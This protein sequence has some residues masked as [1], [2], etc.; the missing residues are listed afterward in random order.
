MCE[1]GSEGGCEGGREGGMGGS[2]SEREGECRGVM[3]HLWKW[4]GGS[5][6]LSVSVIGDDSAMNGYHE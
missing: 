5:N 6:S 1:S 2:Y 3:I 4:G